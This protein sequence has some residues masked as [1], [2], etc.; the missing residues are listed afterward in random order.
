MAFIAG[1]RL[2]GRKQQS[3]DGHHIAPAAI[4]ISFRVSAVSRRRSRGARAR[5]WRE[6]HLNRKNT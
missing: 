4:S 6:G 2:R 3:C 1:E 5:A